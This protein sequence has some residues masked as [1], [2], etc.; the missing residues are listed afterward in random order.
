MPTAQKYGVGVLAFSPLAGGMLSDTWPGGGDA[1][2]NTRASL[3]LADKYDLSRPE[4]RGK[5]DALAALTALAA[6]SGLSLIHLAIAFTLSHP[7]VVSAIVGAGTTTQLASQLGSAE[8]QLS[9]D[10]LDA[11]DVIVP[12]G[13]VFDRMDFSYLPPALVDPALR[14]RVHA[15]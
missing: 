8:V 3:F 7:A 11:I 6:D 2:T 12:P 9:E 10:L 13:T 15:R 4:N 5:H 14:R 1:M